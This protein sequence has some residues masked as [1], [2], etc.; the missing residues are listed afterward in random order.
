MGLAPIKKA[1][2]KELTPEEQ[3]AKADAK[4][5]AKA[6]RIAARKAEAKAAR[7]AAKAE[8]KAAKEAAKQAV[9][10]AKVA[11]KAA[12]RK[13]ARAKTKEAIKAAKIEE[14]LAK[15][16]ALAAEKEQRKL[17]RK[18]ARDIERKGVSAADPISTPTS[19]TDDLHENPY[20]DEPN[21]LMQI[22]AAI[23]E[24]IKRYSEDRIVVTHY[25]DGSAVGAAYIAIKRKNAQG[26]Q[27]LPRARVNN[28]GYVWIGRR[29]PISS[30]AVT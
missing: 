26:N 28:D 15:R 11:A 18:E 2:E 29:L 23:F 3:Q 27:V 1:L 4:V 14:N 13:L 6:A 22:N 21:H 20:I 30:G 10:D 5:A 7:Q 8:E 16:A 25:R 17:D 24:M 19:L 9:K 12:E